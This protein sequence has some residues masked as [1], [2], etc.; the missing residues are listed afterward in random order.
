MQVTRKKVEI[1]RP[2]KGDENRHNGMF[3]DKIQVE[4]KRPRKGD[5]N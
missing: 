3:G 1:K 5:E 2:R 4:I